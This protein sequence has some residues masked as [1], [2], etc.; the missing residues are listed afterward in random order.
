MTEWMAKVMDLTLWIWG[1]A[2]FGGLASL[3]AA[4]GKHRGGLSP[5]WAIWINR[6]G[7]LMMIVSMILFV[8]K[9]FS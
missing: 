8:I 6:L 7:Y 3:T 5:R 2:L 4:A 1:A 9:G